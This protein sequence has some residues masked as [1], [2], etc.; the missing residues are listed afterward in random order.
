MLSRKRKGVIDHKED[1]THSVL[2]VQGQEDRWQA[3]EGRNEE[4][5]LGGSI[6]WSF[7]I[8][9]RRSQRL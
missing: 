6:I 8:V 2:W 7:E 5:R 4:P 9:P 1:Y 3:S